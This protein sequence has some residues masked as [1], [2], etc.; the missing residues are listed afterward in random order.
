MDR[1]EKLERIE[2]FET[3]KVKAFVKIREIMLYTEEKH[4]SLN[5]IRAQLSALQKAG[6]MTQKEMAKI[7]EHIDPALNKTKQIH[8]EAVKSPIRD[9]K[10]KVN[11]STLDHWITWIIH[12]EDYL[13][14]ELKR[15]ITMAE[16]LRDINSALLIEKSQ[17]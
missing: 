17:I 15:V 8:T 3:A 5:L 9:L 7:F 13:Q 10:A 4:N 14:N 2:D 6:T 1:I 12:T 11:Y 16:T